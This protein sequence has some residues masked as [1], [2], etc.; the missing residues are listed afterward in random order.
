MDSDQSQRY[1][2]AAGVFQDLFCS[3]EI[4]RRYVSELFQPCRSAS[5]VVTS[6]GSLTVTVA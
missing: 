4:N 1:V 3:K 2:L 6:T 5:I